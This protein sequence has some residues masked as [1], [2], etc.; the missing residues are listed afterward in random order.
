MAD[1]LFNFPFG[2]SS[3]ATI[4]NLDLSDFISDQ[5]IKRMTSNSKLRSL[6]SIRY[7]DENVLVFDFEEGECI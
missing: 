5:S 1:L 7:V 3:I 6:R 2:V 4:L